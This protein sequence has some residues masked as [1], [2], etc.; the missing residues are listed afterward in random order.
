MNSTISAGAGAV[1]VPAVSQGK[2]KRD[3]NVATIAQPLIKIQRLVMKYKGRVWLRM[4]FEGDTAK[5]TYQYV[6]KKPSEAW[7]TLRGRYDRSRKPRALM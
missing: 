2:R 3:R 5:T 6:P 1:K 7:T 4:K